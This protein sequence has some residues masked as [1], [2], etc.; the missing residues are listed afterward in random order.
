MCP[1]CQAVS[2]QANPRKKSVNLLKEQSISTFVECSKMVS[3]FWNLQQLQLALWT[4]RGAL[5]ERRE[6]FPREHLN[7]KRHLTR[8]SARM[9]SGLSYGWSLAD[10]E[11]GWRE[12]SP[13]S[14]GQH[15]G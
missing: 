2:Q 4:L 14:T 6:V 1:I 7:E 3:L 9:E 8:A 10:R 13:V 15:A 5:V 11:T 12:E